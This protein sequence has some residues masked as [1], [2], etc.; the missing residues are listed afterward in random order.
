MTFEITSSQDVLKYALGSLKRIYKIAK[1]KEDTS[2]MMDITDRLL[3]LYESM[4]ETE[5]NRRQVP[6]GFARMQTLEEGDG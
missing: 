3:M 5:K 6:T 2:L 1:K 4:S